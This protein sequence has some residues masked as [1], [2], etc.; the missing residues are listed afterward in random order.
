MRDVNTNEVRPLGHYPS[1]MLQDVVPVRS[2]LFARLLKWSLVLIVGIV[3]LLA[4]VGGGLYAMLATGGISS[5]TVRTEI[6]QQIATLVGDQ[7]EVT[8]GGLHFSLSPVGLVDIAARDVSV[9]AKR[10]ADLSLRAQSL[11]ASLNPFALLRASLE[12]DE[13]AIDQGE[14][15]IPGLQVQRDA[16]WP[17]ELDLTKVPKL[18]GDA[19]SEAVMHLEE[20]G[21]RKLSL[22]N[23]AV[24]GLGELGLADGSL[25]LSRLGAARSLTG[26]IR[27]DALFKTDRDSVEMIARVEP[28]S[29]GKSINISLNGLNTN[30]FLPPAMG[31]EVGMIGLDAPMT[32]SAK[33]RVSSEGLLDRPTISLELSESPVRFGRDDFGTLSSAQINLRLI[34]E[35]N[36]IEIDPSRIALG[37]SSA[38]LTGGV[39]FQKPGNDSPP[40]FELIANDMIAQPGDSF[41]PAAQGT[42]RVAGKLDGVEKKIDIDEILLSTPEGDLN[43]AGSVGLSTGQPSLALALQVERMEV[44]TFK[45]FWPVFVA[46]GVR[47]WVLKNVSDGVV[48]NASFTSAIP[49]GILGHLKDGKRFLPEHMEARI[50]LKGVR[51]KSPG[52]LPD[53]RSIDGEVLLKGMETKVVFD[54][55]S[56]DLENGRSVDVVSALLD[57]PDYGL[58]PTPAIVSMELSG[59][60]ET[61]AYLIDRKPLSVGKT[62]GL[63]PKGLTGDVVSNV[64]LNFPLTNDLDITTID[65]RAKVKTT[66]FSSPS[67]IDGRV[68]KNANVIIDA[69]P[70][71]A[72]IKGKAV[73]DGAQADIDLAQPFGEGAASV[74]AR[75]TV[76]LIVD[77]KQRRKL[78]FDLAPV[79]TGPVRVRMDQTG[80]GKTSK[81]EVD[82]KTAV[83]SLPWVNWSKGR[84]IPGKASFQLVQ[85]GGTTRVRD[86]RLS[87]S[88]FSARGGFDF[89]KGGLRSANLTRIQL[90]KGDRFS[91]KLNRTRN[92]YKVNLN[93][94]QYDARSVIRKILDE[95]TPKQGA[96]SDRHSV[97]LNAKLGAVQG[98]GGEIFNDVSL[99]YIQVGDNVRSMT[100]VGRSGQRAKTS[101]VM[102]PDK[103]RL[104]TTM[105]SANAGAALRFLD[106]YNKVRGGEIYVTMRRDNSG[107]DVGSVSMKDFY[108]VN[109]KRIRRLIAAPRQPAY[110]ERS[111]VQNQIRRIDS[112]N[113]SV[114]RVYGDIIKGRDSLVLTTGFLRGGDVGAKFKGLVYDGKGRMNLSGTFLPA[115]GLNNFASKIPILGLALGRGTTRGLI[116][117][118]FRL[119]GEAKNPQVTV[120][121]FSLIA[122]GFLRE[123]FEFR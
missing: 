7:H 8:I 30:R 12:V 93:G 104:K 18:A 118:T 57:V 98:F 69:V 112:N 27:V 44:G 81:V 29:N 86:F 1:A 17:V 123:I 72:E 43:G 79:V 76:D 24:S 46:A 111:G 23:I 92:G 83:L 88:G 21:I 96:K 62:I 84:G 34:A 77:D 107:K 45:Q 22:K 59:D 82:L 65:W 105:L 116:G 95:G 89:D 117:V 52:D 97:E 58:K 14:V 115:Y 114:N 48:E 49:P 9:V 47:R 78:G 87:G 85:E 99:K 41:E 61:V 4:V 32:F 100:L 73:L 80:N 91:A 64:E 66:K 5:D 102:E 51:M 67:P 36:Q 16:P 28:D 39:R 90:N 75:Q 10:S 13:V 103:G 2:G 6:E 25:Q 122:P 108:L 38:M 19:I 113:V 3:V 106:I 40:I 56:A 50:P 20:S 31:S 55:G 70:G 94:T 54:K 109:E 74:E 26:K 42:M 53:V 35:K 11:T 120:N 110:N 68:V 15:R 71:L 101:I 33:A 121:P 60:A 63:T 119:T 37:R